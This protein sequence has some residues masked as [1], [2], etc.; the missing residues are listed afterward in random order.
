MFNSKKV[1]SNIKY[2]RIAA[3]TKKEVRKNKEHLW[4]NL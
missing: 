4:K 1:E 2:E 3:I